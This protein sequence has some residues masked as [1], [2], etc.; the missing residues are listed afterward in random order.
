MS[1]P[2]TTERRGPAMGPM[3]F[4]AG[5]MP[6]EKSMDFKA[7]TLRLVGMMRPERNAIIAMLT[8][9]VVSVVLSVLIP[10][11][12]GDATDVVFSGVIGAQFPAGQS[13]DQVVEGLRADGHPRV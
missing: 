8:F 6:P 5:A 10:K 1:R 7:S 13:L 3:R 12:L 2:A 4:M 9:G 11:V